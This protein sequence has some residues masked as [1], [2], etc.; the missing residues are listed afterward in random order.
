MCK[1]IMKVVEINITKVSKYEKKLENN[2][3]NI[4]WSSRRLEDVFK[5]CLED[6][7]RTYLEDI[8]ETNK[9]FTGD[10]CI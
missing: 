2:P 3:A 5:T 9:M 6:I 7:S 4:C 10:I 1:S 8:L